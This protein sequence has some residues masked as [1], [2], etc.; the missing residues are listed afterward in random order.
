MKRQG[1]TPKDHARQNRLNLK[2]Q[3]EA[4]RKKKEAENQKQEK[5][6]KMKKYKGV[7]SALASRGLTASPASMRSESRSESRTSTLAGKKRVQSSVNRL[8]LEDYDEDEES[9]Y[10]GY[11]EYGQQDDQQD[12]GVYIPK[13]DFDRLQSNAKSY[14]NYDQY[15]DEG[16]A[17]SQAGYDEYVVDDDVS[18]YDED[19][20]VSVIVSKNVGK[21]VG[22]IKKT[23]NS[24]SSGYQEDNEVEYGYGGRSIYSVYDEEEDE[25]TENR[26][27]KSSARSTV[28]S[29]SSS[30]RDFIRENARKA[31]QTR[32]LSSRS[33]QSGAGTNR[34]S[35][36]RQS[37]RGN[38]ENGSESNRSSKH[39]AYGKV[40]EY[41]QQR[42]A[43][44][45]EQKRL[46]EEA[47]AEID[48]DCPPGMV[49]LP[50]EERVETLERLVNTK[51]ELENQLASFV[52]VI[53]TEGQKRRKAAIETK[54]LELDDAIRLFS[55]S[56]VYVALDE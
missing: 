25:D 15:D 13:M 40:P 36:S 55:R 46:E 24:T 3:Q 34:S 53:H 9:I 38:R 2:K 5:Q 27:E 1:K 43:E 8:N 23:K 54:L 11:H 17:Y 49:A 6:F 22:N 31:G 33:T 51:K 41:L 48:Y 14:Q 44:L 28:S 50:D 4:N 30:K 18:V 20:G 39:S 16:D 37:Q 52:V 35:V 10:N 45:E 42:K 19:D 26:F 47:L 32:P 56:K 21:K 12:E 29:T 7:R